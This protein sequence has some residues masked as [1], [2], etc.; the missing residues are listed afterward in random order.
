MKTLAYYFGLFLELIG[1]STMI[2]VIILFFGETKMKLLLNM[3]ILS[4][5]EFYCGYLLLKII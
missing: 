5:S 3:S 1:M 2:V 4:V